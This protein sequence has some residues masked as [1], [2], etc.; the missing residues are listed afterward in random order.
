[1]ALSYNPLILSGFDFTG[2]GAAGAA[3]WREPVANEAALPLIGNSN[4]EARVTLD[5]DKIYVWDAS[6]SRWVDT[7]ITAAAFGSTPN[8]NGQSISVDDATAN[9]RRRTLAI[10]PADASNPGGVSIAS[11]SFAGAKTFL[12]PV[13]VDEATNQVVLGTT[14]TTTVNAPNPSS[15]RVVTIPDAGTNSSVVLTESAQS[16]NGIKTFSSAVIANAGVDVT[17]TGGTDTLTIGGTNADVINIGHSGVTVNVIGTTFNENVTNL[18]VTDKNI[19]LNSGGGVGSG[20][21]SGID[22]EENAVITGYA[23]VSGDRNSWSLK[24]PNT[25]G[26][27]VITPG[28]SGITLN[29]SSHDPVT[30]AAVGAVPNAN[31][32]TLTGQQLNL[33]PA[34]GAN[35]GILTTGAQTLGGA[36]TFS[37]LLTAQSGISVTGTITT[38]SYID[39]SNAL[40]NPAHLE[41]RVFWDST[42]HTLAIF[43][44]QT[45]VTHQLGQETFVRAKNI[46]GSTILDGS[47]V[48]ISG[49]QGQTPTIALA[50]A[51]VFGTSRAVGI[52]THDIPNNTVGLTTINGLVNQ[53]DT[54]LFADGA[55]LYVS[56]TTAGDITDTRPNAPNFAVFV[57]FNANTHLNQG[58]IL[59]IP[60]NEV[61]LGNGTG[62]QV[63]GMNS[64]G[65]TAEYK[66]IVQNGGITVTNT[67]NTITIASTNP[68][69]T[70]DI[71]Q[72]SW[73]GLL[74]N[75]SNQNITG[76][77]FSN[78]SVRSFDVLLS[79]YI[80][81]TTDQYS[82]FKL[83]G[84]Q[85]LGGSWE[86]STEFVGDAISGLALGIT[87]AGQ[88]QISIGNLT[89]FNSGLL[90][91]RAIVT[92]I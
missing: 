45:A 70:G 52:V 49:S 32:A 3:E 20:A 1:M 26:E 91:F 31:G 7:G 85:K 82:N 21:T 34:N 65:T 42:N 92:N 14:N 40:A 69:S 19:T 24:A 36:K 10:Q 28:A 59:V 18:N 54:S 78:A 13:R 27:A 51:D 5:S 61:L 62:N 79:C 17:A 73:S 4:G 66:T 81:A 67:P 64:A 68:P 87:G 76:L 44:D 33:Q 11:Q 72:T 23:E 60:E 89:G 6:S 56:A 57:G 22:V 2:G 55:A 15:N 47:V 58:K 39:F 30:L 84:I 43:N 9:I 8:A 75:T 74:N 80:D 53:V 90:K 77:A 88:V 48:Y 86:M 83:N 50:K 16:I 37:S 29:Q 63:L 12:E 25:A 35:P 38:P 41:G 71:L 46:T